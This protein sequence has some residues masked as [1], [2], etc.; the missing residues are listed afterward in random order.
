MVDLTRK[1]AISHIKD[2]ICENN[3][4]KPNIVV[5]E[6]EKE[7]L[8]MAISDMRRVEQLESYFGDKTIAKSILAD[9]KEFSA[10]LERIKFHVR[11]ADEYARK[12]ENLEAENK[13]LR[14]GIE[15][16]K[17]MIERLRDNGYMDNDRY[18]DAIDDVQDIID[19]IDKHLGK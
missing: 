13:R 7:A 4:I 19:D 11:K 1:E 17:T 10:W 3:T 6:Q 5:F 15:N 9:D 14:D 18:I 8:Y 12:C 16:A 2:V